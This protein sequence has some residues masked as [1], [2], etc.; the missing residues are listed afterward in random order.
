MRLQRALNHSAESEEC[1]RVATR[2]AE[3]LTPRA[4]TTGSHHGLTP[5]AIK[6]HLFA[7]RYGGYKMSSLLDLLRWL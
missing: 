4:H 3:K 5:V 7:I 1:R 2:M 6:Y